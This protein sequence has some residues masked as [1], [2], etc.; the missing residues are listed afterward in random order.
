RLNVTFAIAFIMASYCV[1]FGFPFCVH[2]SRCLRSPS[3]VL[4]CASDE[5]SC[6]V[7]PSR[8]CFCASFEVPCYVH[9]SRCY[10][11]CIRRDALLCASFEVLFLYIL[12][13]ALLC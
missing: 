8:C 10:V 11:L 13:G 3:G 2:P 12:R 4:I 1:S 5:M 7:H 6:Y 9:P